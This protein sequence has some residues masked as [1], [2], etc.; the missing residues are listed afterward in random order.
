M[1]DLIKSSALIFF[2]GERN[3]FLHFVDLEHKNSRSA[4]KASKTQKY[5]SAVDKLVKTLQARLHHSRLPL[6]TQ[7]ARRSARRTLTLESR[8][9]RPHPWPTPFYSESD[10]ITTGGCVWG[11]GELNRRITRETIVNIWEGPHHYM[12]DSHENRQ[13]LAGTTALHV[14]RS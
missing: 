3:K 1:L 8:S 7:I 9:R 2:G 5:S 13:H 11:G 12:Y 6:P 4:K 14:R 10:K